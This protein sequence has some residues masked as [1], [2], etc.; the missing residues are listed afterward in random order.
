VNEGTVLLDHPLMAVPETLDEA[1]AALADRPEARVLAGG[2]ELMPDLSWGH[3]RPR[4]FVSL[5][6]LADMNGLVEDGNAVTIG[7]MTRIVAL[8]EGPA[9][10]AVPGLRRAAESLGTPQVRN[11]G[12]LGG[13]VMSALPFRN[14]LPVL[15]ALDAEIELQDLGGT[16]RVPYRDFVVGPGQTVA[17]PGELVTTIRVPVLHGYQDYV[18]VGGRNAQVVATASVAIAVDIEARA[19][20][21]GMGNVGPVPLRAHRAEAFVA[22]RLDWDGTRWAN[23]ELAEEFGRLAAADASPADDFVASADY[24]RRAV[25]VMARR[26]LQRA[27]PSEKVAA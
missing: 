23:D 26:L 9:G 25:E 3:Y 24:R 1:F 13:N 18:K 21:L 6:H 27:F 15:L 2:T 17:R 19:V 16:R 5:G 7:A 10:D 11:Q 8:A 14:F 22:D 4:G 20:R 12:T